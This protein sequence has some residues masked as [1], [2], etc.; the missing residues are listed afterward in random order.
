MSVTITFHTF[1][2]RM[3]AHQQSIIWLQR[4][5]S[6]GFQGFDPQQIEVEYSLTVLDEDGED[7]GTSIC[8][9]KR[10]KRKPGD[11]FKQHGNQYRVDVLLDGWHASPEDLWIDVEEYWACFD[12]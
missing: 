12:K 9:N 1:A 6:F 3:P 11:I 2:E 7:S 5:S 10:W 8:W 4:T